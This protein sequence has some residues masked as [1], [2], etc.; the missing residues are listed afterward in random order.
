MSAAP[1]KW[2]LRVMG[3][4]RAEARHL[5][6]GQMASPARPGKSRGLGIP[7]LHCG[8]V[9]AIPPFKAAHRFAGGCMEYL[10]TAFVEAD[11]IP[12]VADSPNTPKGL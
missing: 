1:S 9:E 10:R 11:F 5:P 7:Q 12:G 8:H 4:Y 2:V 3:S 6:E